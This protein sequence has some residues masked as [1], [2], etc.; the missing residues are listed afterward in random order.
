MSEQAEANRLLE[1]DLARTGARDPR[2]D[3][4]ELLRQIKARS[5]SEYGE[6]VALWERDVIGPTARGEAEPLGR[7]LEFGTRLAD[8]VHPGR[9]V[10][11]DAS[12]RARP[13]DRPPSW[14]EL[15]L[16]LPEEKG[17]RAIPVVVP[18]QPSPAQDATVALLVEGRVKLPD[19]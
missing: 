16:H 4:R 7:W 2:D 9:T 18:P 8:R 3:Y 13:L 15:V 10:A 1:E 12:G 17:A 19:T 11:V 6:A 14:E 5:E